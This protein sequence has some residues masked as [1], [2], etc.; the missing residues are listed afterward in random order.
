MTLRTRQHS[1]PPFA[2]GSGGGWLL[3]LAL[4]DQY[5]KR[6]LTVLLLSALTI[7]L[8][9]CSHT[10]KTEPVGK[11]GV[12]D[13]MRL[14]MTN[15]SVVEWLTKTQ[16][17]PVLLGQ[18]T[19]KLILPD[20]WV[21]YNEYKDKNGVLY[22]SQIHAESDDPQLTERIKV[23]HQNIEKMLIDKGL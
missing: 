20:G 4:K 13:A 3:T 12:E 7:T 22:V 17:T 1:Q 15:P 16:A 19:W 10:I 18:G 2:F 21:F 8:S 6:I 23:L 14:Y 11:M 9:S 5:M